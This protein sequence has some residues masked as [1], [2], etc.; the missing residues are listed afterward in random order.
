[1][2]TEGVSTL[3]GGGQYLQVKGTA[4]KKENSV[5]ISWMNP[6]FN[7]TLW[8]FGLEAGY[9]V[10]EIV[11]D[12]YK[13]HTISTAVSASHPIN[14]F[15]N[16]G[17]RFRVK[18]AIIGVPMK[19]NPE[20][21]TEDQKL[22]SGIIPGF[23]VTLAYDS[24]DN[25]YKP[26][27]GLRSNFEGEFAG[28]VRR[29]DS[30]LDFPFLKFAYLNSYYLP[31]WA[32]GTLKLRGDLKFINPL[33]EGKGGDLPLNERFFLGGE[34]T[35]RGYAPGK[36]GPSYQPGAP[37]GGISSELFSIEYLQNILKPLDAFV[38]FDSGAISLSSFSLG[39]LKMSTGAGLR[40]DVGNQLPFV[41]GYGIP[42]NEPDKSKEQRFFFSMAGQ[43]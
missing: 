13:L 30:L 18:D 27:R 24:T 5:N 42:L 16:Y 2:W 33:W 7:D 4:G 32:R 21:L 9:N 12:V 15:L 11:S 6:Y 31:V 29:D 14:T 25:V 36:I 8:R 40:F 43:F 23:G 37:T 19:N 17:Y 22:N 35:V 41:F 10:N 3:R 38:F 39:S 1:M 34:G 26:H 20:P 28:I